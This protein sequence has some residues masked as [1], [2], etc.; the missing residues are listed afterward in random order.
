[1]STRT[2]S[3]FL[4]ASVN[5]FL[6]VWALGGTA[7]L[8]L[9]T[10]NGQ[11]TVGFNCTLGL[12]GAPHSLPPSQPATPP[13]RQPRHRGP[14]E[15]ERNRQRAARHQAAMAT[16]STTS[17]SPVTASVATKSLSS[18]ASVT[19]TSTTASVASASVA[20]PKSSDS[21]QLDYK[22]DHCEF[23]SASENALGIHIGDVHSNSFTETDL[24]TDP[25]FKIPQIDGEVDNEA[26]EQEA[27]ILQIIKN[28]IKQVKPETLENMSEKDLTD[29]N[30]EICKYVMIKMLELKLFNATHSKASNIQATVKSLMEEYMNT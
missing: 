3:H 30:I 1:M 27:K 2:N 15:I 28:Q 25:E 24:E 11:A 5:E 17:S 16:A 8:T 20:S 9:T 23:K 14:S 22:C 4:T 13:R 7:S 26:A 18:T 6:Q 12:P 19:T 29:L 21:Q 10:S